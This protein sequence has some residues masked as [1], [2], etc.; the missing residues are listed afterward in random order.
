MRE[1]KCWVCGWLKGKECLLPAPD[2]CSNW[3]H[4]TP[5]TMPDK[6]ERLRAELEACA[7]GP[8]QKEPPPKDRMEIF[9]YNNEEIYVVV[10]DEYERKWWNGSEF[11][12]AP[13]LKWAPINLPAADEQ[14]EEDEQVKVL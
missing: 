3:N 6:I 13:P 11:L 4:W 2:Q 9:Y 7:A 10:W 12:E 5:R 14:G 8:W 1:Q